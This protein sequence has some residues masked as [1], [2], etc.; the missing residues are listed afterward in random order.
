[1]PSQTSKVPNWYLR[2]PLKILRSQF[3]IL[4]FTQP[5]LE[6]LPRLI[7]REVH[8]AALLPPRHKSAIGVLNNEVGL[9]CRRD[10]IGARRFLPPK[11]RL[12][13]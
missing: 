2:N 7:I 9:D 11:Y 13:A 6:V 12:V 10:G 5:R 8:V 3:V 1:M 4:R